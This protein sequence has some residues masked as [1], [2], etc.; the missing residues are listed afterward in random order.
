MIPV[1]VSY[2]FSAIETIGIARDAEVN[3]AKTLLMCS[4]SRAQ[5]PEKS[6][7]VIGKNN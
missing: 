7:V 2:I 4:E 6:M 1:S 5:K 3:K